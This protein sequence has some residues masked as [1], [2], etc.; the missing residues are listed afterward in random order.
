MRGNLLYLNEKDDNVH[1]GSLVGRAGG[2][3]GNRTPVLA[4]NYINKINATWIFHSETGSFPLIVCQHLLASF[5]KSFT[6]FSH[7]K[8]FGGEKSLRKL[9]ININQRVEPDSVKR[10]F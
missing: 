7:T 5:S 3:G 4:V 1:A 2:G 10:I 6:H 8:S 9:N